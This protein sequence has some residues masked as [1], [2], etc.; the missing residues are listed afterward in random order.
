MSR[1][2]VLLQTQSRLYLPGVPLGALYKLWTLGWLESAASGTRLHLG[3][4]RAVYELL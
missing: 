1:A 2:S 3:G 4:F